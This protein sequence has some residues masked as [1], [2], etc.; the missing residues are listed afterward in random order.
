MWHQEMFSSDG[1]PSLLPKGRLLNTPRRP[2]ML[3][4]PFPYLRPPGNAREAFLG[5][6]WANGYRGNR[7]IILLPLLSSQ[8]APGSQQG[9][10]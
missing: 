7:Q 3:A 8:G 5:Q 1:K 9:S 10:R 2:V 4:S 6:G